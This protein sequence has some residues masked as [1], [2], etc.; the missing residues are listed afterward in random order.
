MPGRRP[1][2]VDRPHTPDNNRCTMIGHLRGRI[3]DKRPN[4]AVLDVGGVGYEVFIPLS[5][6]YALGELHQEV[7]LLIHTHVRED[8]LALYGFVTAREKQLF[9]L[10]LS[11]SGV[12]PVLALKILSG[13]SVEELL[14]AIRSGDLARLTTIPGVGRKTAE[15]IVVELRDKMAAMEAPEVRPVTQPG[16]T[17]TDAD[18]ISALT[19]LGYDPRVAEKAVEDA[20]AAGADSGFE[21]LLRAA[22]QALSRP[23]KQRARAGAGD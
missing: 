17:Q 13:M 9:E 8:Q 23:M 20:R 1:R 18:V 11:A 10:L 15:R 22:L 21:S 3:F 4:Q 6:F 7:N 19:N 5:T 2:H 16:K 14:P 12:G